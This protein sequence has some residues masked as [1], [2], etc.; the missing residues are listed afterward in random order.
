MSPRYNLRK[1][2]DLRFE[3]RPDYCLATVSG[4]LWKLDV[5]RQYWAEIIAHATS[6]QP[7]RLMLHEI[8]EQPLST[9]DTFALVTELC[10]HTQFLPL[11]IAVL[12]KNP[13]HLNRNK[14]AE[15]IATNR[16]FT[17]RV[18][19]DQELAETWLLA[20]VRAAST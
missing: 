10:E 9:Q 13:A 15:M 19:S 6:T 11:R 18:F 1:P 16:G 3:A 8:T 4:E 7:K 14:L 12:D 17:V 5:T 20:N 2:Y